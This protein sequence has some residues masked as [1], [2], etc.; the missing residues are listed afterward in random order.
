MMRA[1]LAAI[2]I[3]G[4]TACSSFGLVPLVSFSVAPGPNEISS[5]S[6]AVSDKIYDQV[7][8]CLT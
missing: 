3:A 6:V 8:L 5:V 1:A 7:R 4:D 2:Y